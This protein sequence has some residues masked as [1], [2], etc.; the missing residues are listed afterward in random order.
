M[1]YVEC[2]G[3]SSGKRGQKKHLENGLWRRKILDSINRSI[4]CKIKTKK[5]QRNTEI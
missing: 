5:Y 1:S 4:F 3:T 2:L